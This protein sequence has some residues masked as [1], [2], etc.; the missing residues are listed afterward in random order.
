MNLSRVGVLTGLELRQRARRSGFY[1]LLG[2]FFVVVLAIT[3]LG[4]LIFAGENVSSGMISIA[5]CGVLLMA[6][7]V[8]PTFTGN[9]IN[10]D[11]D[12]ATLAPVQVTLATTADI[13]VSKLLAG[14]V[15]GLVYLIVALPAL[16]YALVS[17]SEGPRV[18]TLAVAL[19]VLVAEVGIISAIGVGLSAVIA[20]PLFSVAAT[21]LEVM[22]LVIGTLIAFGLGT[23]ASRSSSSVLTEDPSQVYIETGM[24][25]RLSACE[26]TDEPCLEPR[27]DVSPDCVEVRGAMSMPRAD[28]VWWLLAANPFVVLAD[29]TPTAYD[30]YGYPV[31]VFGYVKLAVREVQR[32][33]VLVQDDWTDPCDG[34]PATDVFAEGDE[35]PSARE[36]ID[37][38]VPSWFVG[39]GVQVLLAVGLMV[40]GASRT[41]TPA[42][43][44]PPGSR[45]A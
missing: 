41:R 39:L 12:A 18:G 45:I 4:S 24:A 6:S 15:T 7:L 42:R 32:P 13:L 11:R 31:D 25:D 14:W 33:P 29:A 16:L 2:I 5:I 23:L 22:L 26:V 27:P 38:T 43:R 21:Y 9:A 35:Y 40:W 36:I 44:T 19:V 20:R 3:W 17:G 28:R 30:R 34:K 1:V 37:S 8:T 10:G